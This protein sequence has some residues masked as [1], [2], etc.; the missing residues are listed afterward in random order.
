MGA[1]FG[2]ERF[3]PPVPRIW[4]GE[5]VTIFASGPSI[6]ES[7]TSKAQGK[8][9]AI[10]NSYQFGAD[11]LY[12]CDYN[13]WDKYRPTFSGLKVTQ[14]ARAAEEFDL[15]RVPSENHPGL[16]LD[17][18]RI[19]QGGNGGYQ[20]INL[21]VLLG[22]SKIILLGYDM[23]GGHWHGKHEGL[24]NPEEGNFKRWIQDYRTIDAPIPILN[25]TPNS[26]LDAF[27]MM[28]MEQAIEY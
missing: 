7:Q 12:G 23:H 18:M 11:L 1:P 16:S 10:N 20:A 17:Q 6:N 21:A 24:N 13:W 26:A 5:V 15:L 14:D 28:T 8:R 3:W 2:V 25:C 22:A 4:E 19:H 27:P 9:L